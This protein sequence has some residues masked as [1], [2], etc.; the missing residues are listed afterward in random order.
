MAGSVP[1]TLLRGKADS[2]TK[3][4]I[5]AF[6]RWKLWAEAQ[7]EVLSFPAQEAH[8]I[9]YLQHLNEAVQSKS[10]IEEALNALSWLHQA[11]V[12]PPVSGLVGRWCRQLW[13]DIDLSLMARLDDHVLLQA[14]N[15]AIRGTGTDL[16]HVPT[17]TGNS[18][19]PSRCAIS[20]R[21]SYLAGW[22]SWA[23]LQPTGTSDTRAQ[24]IYRT[25][26]KD[27]TLH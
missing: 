22:S 9:L 4:Y 18:G 15:T 14:Q 8:I 3:K 17:C 11:P 23:W 20:P 1:D 26:G 10:V 19:P 25:W 24:G 2:T 16:T 7:H 21:S 27:V 6:R 13:Q 12:L 5:G